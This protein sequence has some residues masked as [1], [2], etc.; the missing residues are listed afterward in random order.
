M[1]SGYPPEPTSHADM[2]AK[3]G[4]SSRSDSV[5]ADA[6]VIDALRYSRSD[7]TVQEHR[8]PHRGMP[9][10]LSC[11]PWESLT[12]LIDASGAVLAT[13]KASAPAKRLDSAALKDAH[14][15]LYQQFIK[16]GEPSRRFLIK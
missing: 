11:P 15:D 12:P 10:P 9:R 6:D 8:Q 13:W 3:F 1:Q 4:R 5:L 2:Q 14:P 16:T 7:R